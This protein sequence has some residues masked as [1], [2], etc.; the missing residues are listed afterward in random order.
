M[1]TYWF[2]FCKLKDVLHSDSYTVHINL[3]MEKCKHH[4]YNPMFC[5][6][7]QVYG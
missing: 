5:E 1:F 4:L 2:Q 6:V 3:D 7:S